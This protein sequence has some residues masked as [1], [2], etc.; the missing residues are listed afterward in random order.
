MYKD[1]TETV[2]QSKEFKFGVPKFVIRMHDNL[3]FSTFH[4][5]SSCTIQTLVAN[6]IRVCKF[7]STLEE[8]I[9]FLRNKEESHKTQIIFEQLGAMGKSTVGNV[10]YSPEI[11]CRAFEYLATSRALYHKL[12]TDYQLPGIRTLTRITSKVGRVEDI[13]FLRSVLDNVP[14]WQRRCLLL[15]DEVYVKSALTYHG[16]TLFGRAVDHPDKL[17]KTVLSMMIKCLYGGP[18]FLV[19][20]L[21]VSKLTADFLRE[22]STPILEAVSSHETS[23]I[24]AIIADGHKTNQKCF[25][26]LGTIKN[27]PWLLNEETFLLYDF[28]HVMKCVRNNWI[29]EKSGELEYEFEGKKQVAKWSDLKLL[30]DV[31]C[32]S[33]LKLSKLSY[34]SVYPKPIER[35]SVET[36]LKVFCDETVVALQT[37]PKLKNIDVSGTTNFISIFVKFWKILN[38][39]GIGA[40][41]RFNDPLRA[42]VKFPDDPRL[43]FLKDLG[44]MA[45]NMKKSGKTRVRTLTADTS[46]FLYHT[47]NAF[48][49]LARYLLS[50]GNDYVI[51]GWF[52]TDFLEK[53][54]GKLRQG[55]GGTYFITAQSVLEKMRIHHTKL[56]LQLNIEYEV[57]GGHNCD[58]CGRDLE[59]GEQEIVDNL[60]ELESKIQEDTMFSIIYISGYVQRKNGSEGDDDTF[61][62]YQKFGEYFNKLDRGGLVAPNDS[63]VQWVSLCFIFFNQVTGVVCRNFLIKHFLYIAEKYDIDSI[64][65]K[66][67]RTLA[68]IFLKNSSKLNSPHSAKEANLKVIKLS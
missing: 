31:E 22:Q 68:N 66:H 56:S 13:T 53:Y 61:F 34:V 11:I 52:T 29:T 26:N 36:C 39:K 28:V 51:F 5:G 32:E 14:V 67:C 38:V 24:V 46:G 27:K 1:D 3:T 43:Q 60:A 45:K 41:G 42:V 20:A 49:D 12:V 17:A 35:Q 19:K 15:W 21:P 33:L 47:C 9:N 2:I 62:Y 10:V 58:A 63:I 64:L 18:E 6:R 23:Q 16:G 40:D 57:E 8:I 44:D 4:C 50:C 48:V 65:E 55:S 54:F 7:W 25:K 59:E 37:H 30:Y